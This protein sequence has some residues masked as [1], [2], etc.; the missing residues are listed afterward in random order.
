MCSIYDVFT[1][2]GVKE[3]FITKTINIMNSIIKKFILALA[4]LVLV[5]PSVAQSNVETIT[6]N[7]PHI[8]GVSVSSSFNVRIVKGA[9]SSVKLSVASKYKDRVVVEVKDGILNLYVNGRIDNP[10]GDLMADV[11]CPDLKILK[12]SGAVRINVNSEFRVGQMQI[13]ASGASSINFKEF[14]TAN[15]DFE[16]IASGASNI[17]GDVEAV[18]MKVQASGASNINLE[19]S[20]K[21]V[22]V[23]SSG[24]SSVDCDD[25]DVDTATAIA[26]AASTISLGEVKTLTANASAASKILYKDDNTLVKSSINSASSLRRR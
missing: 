10:G 26:S 17:S 8:K 15:G 25:L 4:G 7:Y 13:S 21:S 1:F 14:T 5:A 22:E 9:S 16:L 2:I 24:A 19:G 12:A 11:V 20:A 23:K 18:N 3:F 6:K